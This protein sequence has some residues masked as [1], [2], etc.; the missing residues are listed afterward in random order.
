[1]TS[2]ALAL[3]CHHLD[4]LTLS[5]TW[6]LGH[7]APIDV[8]QTVDQLNLVHDCLCLSVS[9]CMWLFVQGLSVCP[10]DESMILT[11]FYSTVADLSVKQ[12][13]S[14]CLSILSVL[15]SL[16]QIFF[17][18]LCVLL[19]SSLKHCG[20]VGNSTSQC[21]SWLKIFYGWWCRMSICDW[22]LQLHHAC[23]C[24]C[25][26]RWWWWWCWC[27]SVE[28]NEPFDF[29]GLRMDWYRLQVY[30]THSHADRQMCRHRHGK[31][32]ISRQRHIHTM[33]KCTQTCWLVWM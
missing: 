5:F 27:V 22:W 16:C 10:E 21:N 9:M 33:S 20:T 18:S 12:G 1:M 19:L 8:G 2:Q 3:N 25:C 30:I 31:W 13:I 15:L 6:Q 7:I 28:E 14:L 26:C 24:C 11:S 32:D 4:H 29:R 17:S 23:C